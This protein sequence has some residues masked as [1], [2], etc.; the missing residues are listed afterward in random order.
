MT[1]VADNGDLAP[2]L[3]PDLALETRAT[4]DG[5]RP[6]PERL[7]DPMP[8]AVRNLLDQ[9]ARAEDLSS[10]SW[11]RDDEALLVESCGTGP[12]HLEPSLAR[13]L[14]NTMRVGAEYPVGASG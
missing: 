5:G 3:G 10:H 12:H 4:L 14:A 6:R 2:E 11:V 8:P 13:R 1:S 9:V 7:H